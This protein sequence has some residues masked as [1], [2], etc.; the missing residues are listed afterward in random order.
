MPTT[1]SKRLA[2]RV[3]PA[4]ARQLRDG[5]PWLFDGSIANAP[6]GKPGQIAVVFDRDRAFVAVGLWDPASPIRVRVLAHGQPKTIDADF[7]ATAVTTAIDRR[8]LDDSRHTAWRLINGENDGL[9]GLVAD[10]YGSGRDRVVALKVYT[11]AWAPHLG[12]IVDALEAHRSPRAVVL[13]L[14]RKAAAARPDGWSTG[15]ADGWADGS[16]IRGRLGRL[17]VRYRE[18]NLE[19]SA[20][21]LR[22]QKTGAFLDQRDNRA[23]V[24]ALV[25]PGDRVLD[26]FSCQGGFATAAAAAGAGS[27][28]AVDQSAAAISVV[29]AH[30]AAN[31][32][33][34]RAGDHLV[35]D[36]F[37]ALAELADRRQRF[38]VVVLDPPSFASRREHLS[39]ALGSYRRLTAAGLAVLR[40]GGWLF[41]ASCSA[42][43]DEDSF[44]EAVVA[45]AA[46]Q[47]RPLAQLQT[48][49]HPS[50]HPVSFA[51]GRYLKAVWGR[52]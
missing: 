31:G 21:P 29:N 27:V 20:D 42:R 46:S 52:A 50:D 38:D 47:G 22:G 49:G 45:E 19:F 48:S 3:G 32:C 44:V 15:G 30:L 36:A 6:E 12:V 26:V 37:D 28:T 9:G 18:N 40:P 25:T 51:E 17:P 7:F 24:A 8:S 23:R 13:R 16:V 34:D 35:A 11:E 41:Q 2:V 10:E 33:A 43:V 14:G 4:A 1:D 39:R 5:H